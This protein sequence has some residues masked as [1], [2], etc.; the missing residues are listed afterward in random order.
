MYHFLMLN[1]QARYAKAP[2]RQA[3]LPGVDVAEVVRMHPRAFLSAELSALTRTI[4][5]NIG[6]LQASHSVQLSAGELDL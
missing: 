1:M 6:V 5:A 2:D 3:E 4:S